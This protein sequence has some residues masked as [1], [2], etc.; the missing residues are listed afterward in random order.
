MAEGQSRASIPLIPVPTQQLPIEQSSNHSPSNTSHTLSQHQSSPPNNENL[1]QSSYDEELDH[2]GHPTSGAFGQVSHQH[3]GN[4]SSPQHGPQQPINAAYAFSVPHQVHPDLR[5]WISTWLKT[6]TLLPLGLLTL[7][8]IAAIVGL[9]VGN[10]RNDGIA[11]VNLEQRKGPQ[12]VPDL[13]I[14]IGLL[15]TF[16]PVLI[17]QLYGLLVDS[18]INA[19]LDRQPYVELNREKS[20]IG[21]PAEKSVC[22]EYRSH[23]VPAGMYKALQLNHY[24]LFGCMCLSLVVK[25]VLSPIASHLF[26]TS[27]TTVS[28][29]T[30]LRQTS[31]FDYSG[32]GSGSS[33]TPV[34]DIVAATRVY[35]GRPIPWTTLNESLLP[36]PSEQLVETASLT[37]ETRA[38]SAAADCVLLG[39]DQFKMVNSGN[40]LEFSL[41]DRGCSVTSQFFTPEVYPRV[42]DY[43]RT[44]TYSTC[45]SAYNRSRIVAISAHNGNE[46]DHIITNIFGVSCIPIYFQYATNATLDT[47]DV[48][49]SEVR[50]TSHHSITPLPE[51][52]LFAVLFERG[53]NQAENVDPFLPIYSTNFGRVI[54]HYG[55]TLSNLPYL[56]GDILQTAMQ[57]LFPTTFAIMANTFLIS[58]GPPETARA[59]YYQPRTRVRVVVPV[60]GTIIGI[61]AVILGFLV[62]IYIYTSNRQSIL[63]EEPIGLLGAAAVLRRSNLFNDIAQI[64]AQ[65]RDG[66]VAADFRAAL[67]RSRDRHH[68]PGGW[69]FD[70]WTDP[71]AAR[72]VST[73]QSEEFG[74]TRPVLEPMR[75]LVRF[76]NS[77]LR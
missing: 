41:T 4:L 67:A 15:W 73:D 9:I 58:D 61:L 50:H 11:F 7:A 19:A 24:T 39:P 52:P 35:G 32:Y 25:V 55:K 12:L 13:R 46:S 1:A 17:F 45:P 64:A 63:Y 14:G 57:D 74:V 21:A 5:E 22:L 16:V 42:R 77:V 75:T 70:E 60:A 23:W 71:S 47:S 20:S 65:S 8:I 33:M 68:D 76:L 43:I 62:W 28:K 2:F 69:A 38:M 30:D 27:S 54:F 10:E 26:F 31:I 29:G 36:F 18:V 44:Y 72:V 34:L 51:R 49:Q 37:V 56:D 66:K 3:H 40:G 48:T 53:I 59:T 6:Q